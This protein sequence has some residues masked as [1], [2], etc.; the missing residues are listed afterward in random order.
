MIIMHYCCTEKAQFKKVNFKIIVVID[1]STISPT[2]R[3][4]YYNN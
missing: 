3:L 2:V 1:F 4:I